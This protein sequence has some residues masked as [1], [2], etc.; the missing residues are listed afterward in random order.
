[1]DFVIMLFATF[2]FGSN[3]ARCSSYLTRCCG[4]VLNSKGKIIKDQ[5]NKSINPL[6]R[7]DIAS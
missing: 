1:M 3:A 6:L 4:A 2:P 5:N 7:G